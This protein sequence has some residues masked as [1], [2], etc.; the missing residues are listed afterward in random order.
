MTFALWT[1]LA[2]AMLPY[3]TVAFAKFGGAGY[4]NA[5]PRQ[6][7]ER[8]QG[9]RRRAEWAHRNHFEAFPA[10]AAAV[11]VAHVADAPGLWSDGLAGG[12]IALRVGYTL[13]YVADRPALRSAFW[14]L[15]LGCVI[16]LFGIASPLGVAG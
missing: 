3:V 1:I 9:W 8:L 7:T 13:A 15:A 4:D 5:A 14:F 6:W 12:F 2:A 11:L 16:G 10:F